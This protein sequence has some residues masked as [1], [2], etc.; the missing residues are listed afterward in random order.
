MTAAWVQLES[1]SVQVEKPLSPNEFAESPNPPPV[2]PPEK[3][4]K[5][6]VHLYPEKVVFLEDE[7]ESSFANQGNIW[8]K[9]ALIKK[10]EDWRKKFPVKKDIVLS[11]EAKVT[12]GQLI[13]MYDLLVQSDWPE[14]GINPN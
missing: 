1:V 10:L 3:K 7:K 4:V 13:K 8:N 11:S 5:L 12:Y 14:V 9:P 2:T 6:T